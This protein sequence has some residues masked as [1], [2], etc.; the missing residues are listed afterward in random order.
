MLNFQKIHRERKVPLRFTGSLGR[1]RM[2]HARSHNL[3]AL[4]RVSLSLPHL[5]LAWDGLRILQISD[6]HAGPFMPLR[7]SRQIC[8]LASGVGAD[9]IVFTGDQLDR[10]FSDAEQFVEGFRG[11]EAPLGVWGILG[12][13]DHSTDTD[14]G[15]WALE[16]AGITPLVNQ[17]VTFTRGN[18]SLALI[19]LDDLQ[20]LGDGPDFDVIGQN[21]HAF[22]VTLCHQPNG[23]HRAVHAGAHL[24]LAGHTHGGQIALTA[25]NLNAAR[26]E[27]RYIAGPYRR[28]DAF[29]YV[30]R[31]VGVGAMPVRFGAPPEIDLLT[32][33]SPTRTRRAA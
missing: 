29:L 26:M 2:R 22:R 8:R 20:S 7:R 1:D 30:S 9:M 4:R 33:R 23:W 15:V 12:N 16:K 14:L 27:T 3:P 21:D 17:S 11:L 18:Q 19:G 24:M 31:G 5:P 25:R 13:H 6:V 28:E 10:R 32:L